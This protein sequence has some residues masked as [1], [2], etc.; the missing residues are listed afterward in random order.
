MR[1]IFLIIVVLGLVG[2]GVGFLALGAFPPTPA[3]QSTAV[4]NHSRKPLPS[5]ANAIDGRSLSLRRSTHWPSLNA[6]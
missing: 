4:E 3:S 1:R 5:S 2:L 6:A